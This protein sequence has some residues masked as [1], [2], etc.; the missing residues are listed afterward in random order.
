MKKE[1]IL[2]SDVETKYSALTLNNPTDKLM[3]F[4]DVC[5]WLE[6]QGY[7][8]SITKKIR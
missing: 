3:L 1:T 6:T 8:I 7:K 4:T 5:K 2:W